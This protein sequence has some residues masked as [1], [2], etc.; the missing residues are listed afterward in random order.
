MPNGYDAIVI[1]TGQS[2]KPLSVALAKA[3]RKTAVIEREHVGGTC[4]NTGC[5][6]T[7]TLIASARTAYAARGAGRYGVSAGAVSVNLAKAVAR[8]DEVVESFRQH[9]RE[10]LEKT[11]NLDLIF[12]EA[13]FKDSRSVVVKLQG[14]GSRSLDADAIIINTGGSPLVPPIPGLI[15]APVCDSTSIM[16]LTHLPDHLLVLGGGYIALEFGQMFGR[17]GSRVSLVEK[18]S[19]LV[20]REDPDVFEEVEKILRE[21]GLELHLDSAATK[22]ETQDDGQIALTVN[23]PQGE[24][25]LTGSHLLV[26]I[27]RVPNSKDLNLAA[28]GVETDQRGYIK[29]NSRL[30]TNVAGIYAMGDIKGGPAFTH[31]SY[32]DFRILQENLLRGGSATITGR[33]VPNTTF[34]DPQLAS[35]GMNETEAKRQRRKVRVAKLPMS[36]VARAIEVSETRGFLKVIVDAESGEILGCTMLGIEGGELMSMI[37]IA[38]MGKLPYTVLK[39]AIFAHPTLAESLNNLFMTLD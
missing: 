32:D 5:T 30:E 33:L 12:G 15:D 16:E 7:K 38:M 20:S 14:G 19:H 9:G 24:K 35:V 2:G 29:V 3:G 13:S 26:A 6:P 11:K 17:F 18:E 21:D 23:S 27:G 22:V 34:I 39:E 37:Q 28:A 31:I 4:I 1:G 25:T 10:T 8:K 36:Q